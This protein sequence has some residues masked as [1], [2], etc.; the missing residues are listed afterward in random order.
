MC[1]K[2][3]QL[4]RK[5]GND[6]TLS[7]ACCENYVSQPC[8]VSNTAHE[9]EPDQVTNIQHF[10]PAKATVSSSS[11]AVFLKNCEFPTHPWGLYHGT[12]L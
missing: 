9:V 11:A 8:E 5:R 7:E 4:L 6:N 10:W 1:N 2:F 3:Q 12:D